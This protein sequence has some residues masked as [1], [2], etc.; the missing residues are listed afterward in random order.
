MKMNQQ[1]NIFFRSVINTVDL[2]Y[3][4]LYLPQISMI[5]HKGAKDKK[6][7]IFFGLKFI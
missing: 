2:L 3:R 6:T 5:K 7:A 4:E 1:C